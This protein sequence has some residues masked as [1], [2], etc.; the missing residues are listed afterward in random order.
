MRRSIFVLF[1]MLAASA[2]LGAHDFWIEPTGFMADLGRVVGVKLRVGQD[3]HG[4][5][6]P[7]SDEL[8]GDFVVV[9]ASGRRQVVGRDG[10]DPAGL[11]RVT[12]PGLMVIGYRS[13]PSA[14][15]L[16]ADKFTA[17]LKEEGLETVI[18]ARARGQASQ[19]EGREIFSRA[20]KSLVRSGAMPAGSGDRA[21]GF[22][23]E[24]IA[25]RNPYQMSMG[26]PLPV[27]LTYQNAPL[28]GALVVA[29]NQRHPYLKK[30][31]RS[32]ENGR[33][34]FPIDEPGPWMVKAVHMVPAT[35]GSNADWES[36]W[37]SLTF[38]MQG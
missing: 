21:L 12:S 31:V 1:T 2:S 3:F 33:A 23:I 15:T 18:D 36:F 20:A 26:E 5:P 25:E 29:F 16:A 35:T 22:P 24:L 14:V 10:S 8:I 27:R 11:L 13:H 32:D 30:R 28:A 19:R 4:D 6:V 7:R 9:D 34:T 38:E 37:A 17:Y